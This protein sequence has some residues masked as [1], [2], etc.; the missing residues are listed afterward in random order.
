MSEFALCLFSEDRS[1]E[2]ESHQ[3]SSVAKNKKVSCKV[4]CR[5][6]DCDSSVGKIKEPK[7]FIVYKLVL[8]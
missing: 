3:Y 2:I 7:A 6:G 4:S 8:I 5:D 1:C